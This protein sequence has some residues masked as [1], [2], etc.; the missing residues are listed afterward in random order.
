MNNNIHQS[1][2]EPFFQ[3]MNK[4]FDQ[5]WCVL[6]SYETLPN[7]SESDVDMAFSGKDITLLEKLI[8]N[9]AKAS[10]WTLY[11]RLWYDAEQ[12]LYY[13][14]KSNEDDFE[15]AIDFLIDRFAVGQ[16][17]FETTLLTENCERWN[18]IIPIPNSSVAF[19]YKLVKRIVKHRD[20]EKDNEYLLS[21][22]EQG[23]SQ[24]I[25]EILTGQFGKEGLSLLEN[26]LEKKDFAISKEDREKLK[27]FKKRKRSLRAYWETQ[28]I[29][30]RLSKPCGMILSLPLQEEESELFVEKLRLKVGLLFRFVRYQ[31][32]A[33]FFDKFKCLIGSTLL[34]EDAKIAKIQTTWWGNSDK[35]NLSDDS[36]LES[37]Y[38][39]I[40]TALKNRKRFNEE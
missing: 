12:S 3:E 35:L 21:H 22:Y 34:I 26:Y 14:L 15:L 13:V 9:T 39:A 38:Q 33:T 37:S 16:Y 31:K 28:R 18:D 20:L 29:F 2:L 11:Q 4:L 5:Q 7:Y 40:L 10:G 17:A 1:F 30:N 19:S 27:R 24:R 36:T 32:S 25:R 23:N 6:H 8:L